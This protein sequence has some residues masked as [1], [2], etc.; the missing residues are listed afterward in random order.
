MSDQQQQ[1][2]ECAIVAATPAA[3]EKLLAALDSIKNLCRE[4]PELAALIG[5]EL[6]QIEQQQV[7]QDVQR[8]E[9]AS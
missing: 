8:T 9:P 5:E 6:N 2:E 7:T 3:K 1:H 4:S